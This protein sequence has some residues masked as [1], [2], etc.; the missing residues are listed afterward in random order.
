MK[1]FDFFYLLTIPFFSYSMENQVL[2]DVN[3]RRNAEEV[4]HVCIDYLHFLKK[5]VVSNKYSSYLISVPEELSQFYYILV[6]N[7]REQQIVP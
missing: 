4:S 1:H 3:N 6:M 5:T 2:L 7:L